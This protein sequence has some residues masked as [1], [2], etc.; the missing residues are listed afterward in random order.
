MFFGGFFM[1]DPKKPKKKYRGPKHLFQADR[2]DEELKVMGK[3]GLRSKR[4]LWKYKTHISNVRGFVRKMLALTEEKRGTRERELLQKLK[5]L[6]I[7]P[8]TATLSDVLN[9]DIDDFLERRLQTVIHRIG[10]AQTVHQARQL[11][12]HGHIAIDGKK[13]TA[14]S[15]I[16]T[17]EEEKRISYAPASPV[18]KQDHPLRQIIALKKSGIGEAEAISEV[19]EMEPEEETEITEKEEGEEE[20][21]KG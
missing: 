10:L 5:R 20:E 11:I 7:L 21:E 9:L 15:Y 14:P 16:V 17:A 4:E 13:K 19:P 6:G 3:Y 18:E 2:I 12:T 8:P 1:G